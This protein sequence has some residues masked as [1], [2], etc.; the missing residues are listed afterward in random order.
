M[1]GYK[2]SQENIENLRKIAKKVNDYLDPIV[3]KIFDIKSRL[4]YIETNIIDF[5]EAKSKLEDRADKSEKLGLPDETIEKDWKEVWDEY[6]KTN[7]IIKETRPEKNL[8]IKDVVKNIK[9]I[10]VNGELEKNI[11]EIYGERD[12]KSWEE[13]IEGLNIALKISP[14][15]WEN[16]RRR[17]ET[18]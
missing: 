11:N 3:K 8:D 16:L 10:D 12:I 17:S 4:N 18:N 13:F 14:S 7:Q 2:N 9:Q 6:E 5:S 1:E 15:H